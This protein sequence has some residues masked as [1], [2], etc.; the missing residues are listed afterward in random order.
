MEGLPSFSLESIQ[1]KKKNFNHI[2]EK[3]LIY[4]INFFS[5]VLLFIDEKWLTRI[6]T[7]I[8][9]HTHTHT[10]IY[11]S[12]LG[13]LFFVL[14]FFSGFGGHAVQLVGYQFPDQ[15]LNLRPQQ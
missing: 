11:I 1:K 8:H 2:K 10:H 6:H 5:N 12:N 9:T 4:L 7:Y 15:G 13:R 3:Y 14:F